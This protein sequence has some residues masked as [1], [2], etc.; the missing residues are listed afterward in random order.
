MKTKTLAALVA[1]AAAHLGCSTQYV[2]GCRLADDTC[3]EWYADGNSPD[4]APLAA[5]CAA[6]GRKTDCRVGYFVWRLIQ[7]RTWSCVRSLLPLR[8]RT[9]ASTTCLKPP[10][11]FIA[12]SSSGSS[13]SVKRAL[14]GVPVAFAMPVRYCTT[15]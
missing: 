14:F 11:R 2:G 6:S 3:L 12:F 5:E 10:P 8:A 1:V 9:P 15:P 7:A 4:T 13:S